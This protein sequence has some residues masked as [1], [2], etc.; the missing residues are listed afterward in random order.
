[1]KKTLA[2]VLYGCAL[3]LLMSLGFW[4]L[5]RGQQKATLLTL[6]DGKDKEPRL[7]DAAPA[8][9]SGLDYQG[10]TL[11]GEWLVERS[12]LLDNRVHGQEVGYEL[13]TPFRLADGSLIIVNRGWI[14]K[15]GA[16]V[17]LAE[18]SGRVSGTIYRPSRGYTIGEAISADASWPK[19]SLYLDLAAFS[20]QLQAPLQPVVLVVDDDDVNSKVR[21]WQ[22]VVVGPSR[23]YGY[24]VQWFGMSLVLMI[25]GVIWAR[26][27]RSKQ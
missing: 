22:P 8:D 15:Q 7:I 21:I 19:P 13:L 2:V 1:M 12:F 10:A 4:Q 18:A 26:K 9:W 11:M 17:A 27:S 5:D 24:A 3:T 25:F 6:A 14:A 16:D 20:E 23:H